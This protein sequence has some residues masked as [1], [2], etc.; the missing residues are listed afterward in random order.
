MTK[1]S[2]HQS[3]TAF[4]WHLLCSLYWI[5][6]LLNADGT[7]LQQM[8]QGCEKGKTQNSNTI[9]YT[10]RLWVCVCASA[11]KQLLRYHASFSKLLYSITCRSSRSERMQSVRPSASAAPVLASRPTT[12]CKRVLVA[13]DWNGKP[14]TNHSVR[15]KRFCVC[16]QSVTITTCSLHNIGEKCIHNTSSENNAQWAVARRWTCSPSHTLHSIE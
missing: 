7:S 16:V 10:E 15:P 12:K 4:A 6:K 13:R 14:Y 2:E 8:L 3:S 9:P 1:I 5:E 11:H